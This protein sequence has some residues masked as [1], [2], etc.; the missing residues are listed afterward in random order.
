MKVK[1]KAE[2]AQ[3]INDL[4]A[5]LEVAEAKVIALEATLESERVAHSKAIRAAAQWGANNVLKQQQYAREHPRGY[6]ANVENE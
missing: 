4:R 3:T 2:L 6:G 1:S 5:A